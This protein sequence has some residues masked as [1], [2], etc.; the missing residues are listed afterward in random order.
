M[1][2]CPACELCADRRAP[3]GGV[4][5]R[6]THFLLHGLDGPTPLRGWTVLTSLRHVRAVDGLNDEELAELGPLVARVMR[7]QRTVLGAEHA[8]VLALGDV[9]HHC[10]VHVVPRF[11]DTP[12]RLRG[13][14]AFDAA[15]EDHLPTGD[16]EL[17]LA[18]LRSAL[19][20]R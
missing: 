7:A 13:R 12:A 14:G 10:H 8:Y 17:A 6:T 16:A 18:A 5:A 20:Q 15:P 4:L 11:A 3:P 2:T 1:S 19:A 9:L